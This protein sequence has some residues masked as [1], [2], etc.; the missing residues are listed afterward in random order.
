MTELRLKPEFDWAK[1]VRELKSPDTEIAEFAF[2]DIRE[3]TLSD[4]KAAARKH[5]RGDG[6]DHED[7]VQNVYARIWE[8]RADVPDDM[9]ARYV[10]GAVR[11]YSIW[12]RRDNLMHSASHFNSSAESAAESHEK[13]SAWEL[14][15]DAA[16]RD[17]K[18][19]PEG[20]ELNEW[21]KSEARA[22]RG[23][24]IPHVMRVRDHTKVVEIVRRCG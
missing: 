9:D 20:P 10:V 24:A 14:K 11:N 8:I 16:K 2:E 4:V 15:R 1:A 21:Q 3:E 18:P 22:Y 17:G 12:H 5:H 13:L 19:A 23:Y 6:M 7:I